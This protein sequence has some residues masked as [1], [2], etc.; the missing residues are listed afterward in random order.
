MSAPHLEFG[1]LDLGDMAETRSQARQRGPRGGRGGRGRGR[2][3][4]GGPST[5]DPQVPPTPTT[6][7]AAHM[8]FT[9]NGRG[10]TEQQRVRAEKG[11]SSAFIVETLEPKIDHRRGR[12]YAL[13]IKKPVALR[14]YAPGTDGTPITCSCGDET[15]CKHIFVS[16]RL[17]LR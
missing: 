1:K 11:F 2:G 6:P 9:Y 3:R 17:P 16:R 10:F 8:R 7:L 14:I 4:G 5:S 12:Y 15:L 13:Q